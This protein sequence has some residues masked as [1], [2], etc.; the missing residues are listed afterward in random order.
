MFLHVVIDAPIK[1]YIDYKA[2]I[3]LCRTTLRT[4]N[5]TKI[6][7]TR[8]NFISTTLFIYLSINQ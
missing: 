2:A 7:N 8:I 6:I 5:R 4:E 3:E 1:I